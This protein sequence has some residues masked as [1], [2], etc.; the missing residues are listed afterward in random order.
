MY[1]YYFVSTFLS[2]LRFLCILCLFLI[3]R[4]NIYMCKVFSSCICVADSRCILAIAYSGKRGVTPSV[5]K[6]ISSLSEASDNFKEWWWELR[7]FAASLQNS[8][9]ESRLITLKFNIFKCHG[10]VEL[11]LRQWLKE[12]DAREFYPLY[13]KMSPDILGS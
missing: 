1:L 12:E 7:E 4:L 8:P 13:S 5:Q 11:R 2:M 6:I 9:P 10:E 3:L